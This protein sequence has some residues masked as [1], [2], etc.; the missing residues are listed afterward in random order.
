MTQPACG[1]GTP[2]EPAIGQRPGA[3][4]RERA[5]AAETRGAAARGA[6]RG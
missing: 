6:S 2:P 4:E 3:V 1:N 5:A